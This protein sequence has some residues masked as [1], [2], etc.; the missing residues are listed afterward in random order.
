MILRAITMKTVQRD[1]LK[2]AK[3]NQDGTLK[4]FKCAKENKKK[5]TGEEPEKI[6]KKWQT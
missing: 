6:N 5:K 4:K 2:N 3:L 1:T